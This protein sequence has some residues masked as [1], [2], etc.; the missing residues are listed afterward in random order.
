[1]IP[2]VG[3]L[4]Y[5]FWVHCTFP[6]KQGLLKLQEMSGRCESIGWFQVE[7]GARRMILS[8]LNRLCC[9]WPNGVGSSVLFCWAQ[10]FKETTHGKSLRKPMGKY[11]GKKNH[12]INAIPF[13]HRATLPFSVEVYSLISL[14]LTRRPWKYRAEFCRG[15]HF[16]G[17][18]NTPDE[19]WWTDAVWKH[20]LPYLKGRKNDMI[21]L[22]C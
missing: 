2:G 22:W 8:R 13:Y 10:G 9:G 14:P 5:M 17:A 20:D 12:G 19:R 7:K 18:E 4:K 15:G 11:Q 21:C 1:M 16:C 6:P 3:W